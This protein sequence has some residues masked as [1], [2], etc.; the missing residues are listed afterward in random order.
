MYKPLEEALGYSFTRKELLEQAL[1]H[2]SYSASTGRPHYERLE[3]L[4][5]AVL[6]LV[7]STHLY[8]KYPQLPEGQLAK[9]RAL[10]VSQPTLAELGRKLKLDAYLK[11]GKGEEMSGVRQR[12]SVLCDV[13]EAVYGAVFL[14][15]G[16][17]A[18]QSVILAHLPHWNE[19][20][21]PVI[22]AK[23]TLQEHFQ[24]RAQ[25]TPTYTLAGEQGPPHD[26]VF[27]VEVWFEND[28]LGRGSGRSKKVAA[29]AA[30][31]AALA[32]LDLI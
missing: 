5:D 28:L 11:V 16:F 29:Q 3:F 27:T 9:V 30:A 20:Q 2:R 23:T 24:Q 18:A 19:E 6:Q 17:S 31:R 21:L 15:G 4:G 22:D 26:K 14:D 10:L 25:K 8:K 1:T 13:V 12:D 32:N 7:V